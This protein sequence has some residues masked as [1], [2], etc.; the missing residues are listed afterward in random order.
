MAAIV[1]RVLAWKEGR[2]MTALIGQYGRWRLVKVGQGNFPIVSI[3]S[4]VH[5]LADAPETPPEA[6]DKRY[7]KAQQ[8]KIGYYT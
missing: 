2:V 6:R 3:V 4:L 1:G 8:S 7:D 5:V